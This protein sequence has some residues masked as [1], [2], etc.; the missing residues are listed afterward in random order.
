M[1]VLFFT[2]LNVIGCLSVLKSEINPEMDSV[3]KYVP[4]GMSFDEY[5]QHR[6]IK[7]S[8]II[9]ILQ[10]KLGDLS[11]F[12]LLD[13]GCHDGGVTNHFA[14]AFKTVVGVDNDA[15]AVSIAKDV[16][17]AENL[18]FIAVDSKEL[19]FG[20]DEFDV[21]VSNHV[22]YYVDDKQ[23]F[24]D[25]ISRTLKVGGVCYL[26]ATNGVYTDL[27]NK[28]PARLRESSTSL[29]LGSSENYGSPLRYEQ[30]CSF[31][32]KLSMTD[33]TCEILKYP[34]EYDGD[35][36]GVKVGKAFAYIYL[37]FVKIINE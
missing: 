21:V 36:L 1:G 35:I 14:A 12:S 37:S 25:E 26:S 22:I 4:I 3:Y 5:H 28:L 7:A 10:S 29:F 33:M 19:P 15:V 31:F 24:M 16:F 18:S 6:A 30:Y 27:I 34:E 20:N 9:K 2:G 23:Y 32:K 13:I 8:K 11:E 17:E